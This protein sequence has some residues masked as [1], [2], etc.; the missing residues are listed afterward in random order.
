MTVL[1]IGAGLAG[2]AA[3]E[4]LA[5]AG[6]VVTVLEARSRIGG[7]VF[8][9]RAGGRSPVA[10]EL[11]AEFL[12]GKPKELLKFLRAEGLQLREGP[13]THRWLRNGETAAD[14]QPRLDELLS[15][16]SKTR[17]DQ[18]FSEF[19]QRTPT[20][21]PTKKHAKAFIEGFNA[22]FADRAGTR[23]LAQQQRASDAIEGDRVFRLPGGLDKLPG[24]LWRRC[25][26]SVTLHLDTIV[27]AVYWRGGEVRIAAHSATATQTTS[28]A[29]DRVLITVPLG[30]LKQTPN[31]AGA[32]RF[33][34]E[35][36]NKLRA[37]TRLEMG[38]VVKVN[39]VVK[40]GFWRVAGG[41]LR[42]AFLHP[43]DDDW[44]P[45]WWSPTP[46]IV[47]GW[48]GGPKAKALLTSSDGVIA[49]RA[50]ESL[51]RLFDFTPRTIARNIQGHRL[52]NW[53]DDPFCRGAYSYACIGGVE[54]RESLAAPIGDRLFFAGEASDT[55]GNSGTVHGA[56]ASGRRAAREILR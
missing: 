33:I 38:Q 31:I 36:T 40:P 29:A 46:R 14:A 26:E 24:A 42:R 49:R 4:R 15:R 34:P 19:L 22:A 9:H 55:E 5:A 6:A 30:V 45:T 11:G 25:A 27:D 50:V 3:A 10:T 37:I 56:I 1:I 28:Y 43:V 52:H 39:V 51:A 21:G 23:A 41:S 8:T 48:A 13:S 20:D 53:A 47:T 35:I 16:L 32:I 54:A 18:T 17:A 12:H 7:R 2:L 44:F